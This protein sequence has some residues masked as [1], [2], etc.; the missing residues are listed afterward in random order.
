M[1]GIELRAPRG[2]RLEPPRQLRD[3]ALPF[4]ARRRRLEPLFV[5][6]PNFADRGLGIVAG[7]DDP[8]QPLAPGRDLALCVPP[9]LLGAFAPRREAGQVRDVAHPGRHPLRRPGLDAAG[10]E[11]GHPSRRP[12][13]PHV[14]ERGATCPRR[15][16]IGPR[17]RQIALQRHAL[18]DEVGDLAQ[19]IGHPISVARLALE[20]RRDHLRRLGSLAIEDAANV[21]PSCVPRVSRVAKRGRRGNVSRGRERSQLGLQPDQ[22]VGCFRLRHHPS[23]LVVLEPA[24]LLACSVQLVGVGQGDD[25]LI[26]VG[27][28]RGTQARATHGEASRKLRALFLRGLECCEIAQDPVGRSRE[29]PDLLIRRHR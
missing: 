3:P 17:R 18:R 5:A 14:Y 9:S 22:T 15:F 16:H 8:E 26:R 4:R 19:P 13:G 23:I 28:E 2:G 24:K 27:R 12:S 29:R 1:L 20:S 21:G 7:A 25:V 11:D 6:S 10:L